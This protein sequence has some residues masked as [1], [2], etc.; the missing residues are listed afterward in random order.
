MGIIQE[1]ILAKNRERTWNLLLHNRVSYRPQQWSCLGT[2]I[3]YY[4]KETSLFVLYPYSGQLLQ[5]P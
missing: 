3:G 2:G 5:K 1:R 4:N